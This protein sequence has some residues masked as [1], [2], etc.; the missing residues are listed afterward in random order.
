MTILENTFQPSNIPIFFSLMY[1]VYYVVVHSSGMNEL[2]SL[3]NKI[4]FNKKILAKFLLSHK[5]ISMQIESNFRD[6]MDKSLS[7]RPEV[8]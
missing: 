4:I 6:T 7:H 5:R 2:S 8:L 1:F 3:F